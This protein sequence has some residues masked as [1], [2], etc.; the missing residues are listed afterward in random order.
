MGSPC[1]CSVVAPALEEPE[2][3]PFKVRAWLYRRASLR[4]F[5]R[6]EEDLGRC[7][8]QKKEDLRNP[9]ENRGYG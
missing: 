7:I 5:E 1:D 9:Y 6:S 4:S 8:V 3:V 2:S